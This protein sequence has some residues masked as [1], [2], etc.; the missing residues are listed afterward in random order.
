MADQKITALTAL[1]DPVVADILPIVDDV[2][3][4]PI[5]KKVTLENLLAVGDARTATLTNKT[6][7]SPT[8]DGT[9]LAQ[10]IRA[11]G[12]GGIEIENSGGT[13]VAIFGAGAGTG[14]SL[15]GTTNMGAA[16]ADYHQVAGGTGTITDTA[17]GSSTNININ[18]VPKGT[19]RLQ[20]GGTTVPTISSTDTLTNKRVTKRTDST[21]SSATPTINTDNVDMYLLTAQT[22]DITS[23]TT[24]LSGTPTQGQTLWISITGTAA[25]A[26]TWGT[27]FEA[28]TVPLPT[29]TVSTDRLDVG[30]VWNTVTSKWRCVA[31]A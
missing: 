27:S 15:N 10:V 21:T 6:L 1:A 25:R 29:T 12:S 13:D 30:F 19:G 17:T 20:A 7:T 23:F 28:S 11:S 4:T 16:S 5:T 18:L 3:G 9:P 26:I 31:V 24:N 8:L 2:A 14:T 22:A